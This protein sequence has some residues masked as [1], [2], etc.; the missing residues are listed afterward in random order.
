MKK[1]LIVAVAAAVCVGFSGLAMADVK[2]GGKISFDT[3]M[4]SFNDVYKGK[5]AANPTATEFSELAFENNS[6]TNL[7]VKWTSGKVGMYLEI[8][9]GN[10]ND[11]TF[12]QSAR[13][14]LQP[15]DNVYTRFS[16]GWY[17]FGSFKLTVGQDTTGFS[18]L[19][20]MQMIGTG[21][22]QFKIIGIGFGNLYSG[23]VYQ[24]RG[25]FKLGSMGSLGIALIDP[26]S[27]S[28]AVGL[29]NSN[30]GT[31]HSPAG[32][33]ETTMPRIDVSAKLKFGPLSIYPGIVRQTQTWDDTAPGD[34]D[35]IDTQIYSLGVKTAFG[36]LGIAAEYNFG[37]NV[38]NA[39]LLTCGVYGGYGPGGAGPGLNQGAAV[40]GGKVYDNDFTGYWAD[41]SYKFGHN[42]IHAIY[43]TQT[44]QNDYGA[45]PD[46]QNTRTMITFNVWIPLAKNFLIIPEVNL[47]DYGAA[48]VT[49]SPDV[50]MGEATI[51]GIGWLIMF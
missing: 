40:I 10:N 41:V 31:I 17:D 6:S 2:V 20:P 47:W 45:L 29:Y 19:N 36:P 28:L 1:F 37:Q 30:D 7:H 32:S 42:T 25:D 9:A 23:R 43:G 3:Y 22:G 26:H 12:C 27:S 18:P 14:D 24:V 34:D 13:G 48:E 35:S 39:N 4:Q 46:V 49:G 8:A 33:E 16:Y 15:A 51:Y 11:A 44:V 5:T 50:E 21:S 38:G